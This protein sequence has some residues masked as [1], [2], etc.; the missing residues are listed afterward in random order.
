MLGESACD[1]PPGVVTTVKVC[2][3]QVDNNSLSGHDLWELNK[4][5]YHNLNPMI[6]ILKYK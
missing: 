2:C 6:Y 1:V 3:Y 4:K 5:M